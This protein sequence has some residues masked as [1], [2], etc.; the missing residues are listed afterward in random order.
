MRR[1]VQTAWLLLPVLLVCGMLASA[2]VQ[3][4]HAAEVRGAVAVVDKLHAALLDVMKNAQKLGFEGRR[5]ELAPVIGRTYDM[6]L[7]TQVALGRYWAQ[8]NDAQ[9]KQLTELLTQFT[10]ATY[11]SRFDG[12]SG[13]TFV[14][15]SS[16]KLGGSRALVRSEIKSSNGG[17]TQLD[18]ILQQSG[19][20]WA[21]INVIADGVSD[22]SLKRAE[23][24]SI[25][26]Q[27]GFESLVQD[28]QTKI[29]N[30]VKTSK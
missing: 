17:T 30:Y 2:P 20:R 12:Y 25:M 26:E 11:A 27:K 13:E 5:K 24:S 16:R 1:T 29:E 4:A 18:Y 8:L 3:A 21:I 10:I 19:Q 28:L 23:F 6:P 7:I 22:L 9:H 14:V 15:E